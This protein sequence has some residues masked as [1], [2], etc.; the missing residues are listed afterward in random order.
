MDREEARLK[1][2]SFDLGLA[3]AVATRA[4]LLAGE[5]QK[6]YAGGET[7]DIERKGEID[8]VTEVDLKCE[9]AIVE[10]ISDAYPDHGIMAEEGSDKSAGNN[11]F[12]WIVDPLDG[13]TNFAHRFPVYC[14]SVA[15]TIDKE[16]SVG[17]VY[18]PTRDEMFTAIKGRGAFLN[19]E[20][21][22]V[23]QTGELID[24]LLATGFPYGIKSVARNNLKEFSA[25]VMKAQAIRRPGA[26]ALDLCY[27]ACGR[28]DGF[29]EFHLKPWDMAGGA[30]MVTEAGGEVTRAD[31]D[32]T[33]IFTPE[34]VASNG[35]IHKMMVEVVNE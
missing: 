10:V 9:K 25:M 13:T 23:S 14:S 33:D 1:K 26:A 24:S 3:L 28:L 21:I 4:A 32:P 29:W 12:L 17:A 30:L 8:L 20:P 19:G 6:E 22:K 27:V 2:N 7:F 34:I 18:D 11:G 5:I 16:R 31:G 15:L 35:V